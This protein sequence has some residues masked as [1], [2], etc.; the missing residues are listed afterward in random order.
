M[1][2][3]K[4][5]EL[6]K[7]ADGVEVELPGWEDGVPFIAK[8]RRPSMLT[9]ASEGQIPN[10]LMSAAAKLFGEGGAKM[11]FQ[12]RAGLFLMMARASLVSPTWDELEEAGLSLTDSQLV[13]IYNYSQTGVDALRRFREGRKASNSA[14]PGETVPEKAQ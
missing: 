8:L 7:Y 2:V 12:E 13:Y 6:K 1:A 11:D 9:L 5:S 3:T 4:I 14:N 10:S